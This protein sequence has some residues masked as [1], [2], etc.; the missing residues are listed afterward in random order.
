[1]IEN[2]KNKMI[3]K[4]W[5]ETPGGWWSFCVNPNAEDW[6]I[7]SISFPS[8][9]QALCHEISADNIEKALYAQCR[10]LEKE[11]KYWK[12]CHYSL[13]DQEKFDKRSDRIARIGH[14]TSYKIA[15]NENQKLREEVRRLAAENHFYKDGEYFITV[16]DIQRCKVITPLTSRPSFAKM[17]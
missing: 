7:G 15:A 17:G 11:I 3:D 10:A 8:F 12:D 6:Q 1:M 13:T 14:G 16:E 4:G 5:K 9:E 2:L